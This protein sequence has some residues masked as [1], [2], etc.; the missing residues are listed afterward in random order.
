MLRSLLICGVPPSGPRRTN[1]FPVA[2]IHS[3]WIVCSGCKT[4]LFHCYLDQKQACSRSSPFWLTDPRAFFHSG[5]LKGQVRKHPIFF[6]LRYTLCY[7]RLLCKNHWLLNRR[8]LSK[9][10]LSAQS[11][12]APLRKPLV[13]DSG[14]GETVMPTD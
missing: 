4:C 3:R 10:C 2:T 1:R 12:W 5:N 6:V 9:E 13:V 7:H 14:A 11:T 8:T